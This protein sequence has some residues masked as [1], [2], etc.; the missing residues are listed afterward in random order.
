MTGDYLTFEPATIL[1]KFP[2]KDAPEVSSAQAIV[3]ANSPSN[4]IV[5]S[6]PGSGFPPAYSQ[7]FFVMGGWTPTFVFNMK[8]ANDQ[9][10]ADRDK[11]WKLGVGIG[12][13]LTVPLIVA[14]TWVLASRK[15]TPANPK[16]AK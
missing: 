8:E 15:R 12:V 5:I 2:T 16:L 14:A 9:A 3:G 6:Q 13:G 1:S 4:A 10:R 11:K 7:Q